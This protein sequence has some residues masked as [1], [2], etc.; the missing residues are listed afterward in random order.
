MT[1]SILPS[2]ALLLALPRPMSFP[3]T[4][5]FRHGGKGNPEWE[6]QEI[7]PSGFPAHHPEFWL[8]L[9]SEDTPNQFYFSFNFPWPLLWFWT[10]TDSSRT[11]QALEGWW[12]KR[13]DVQNPHKDV[14]RETSPQM[15]SEV[16][17]S[18][19]CHSAF[20]SLSQSLRPGRKTTTLSPSP[21]HSV[22][23]AQAPD[24]RV[25]AETGG[26]ER[27]GGGHQ[28]SAFPVSSPQRTGVVLLTGHSSRGQGHSLSPPFECLSPLTSVC[29]CDARGQKTKKEKKFFFKEES[30][31]QCWWDYKW[32]PLFPLLLGIS[33]LLS[34]TT[35][36]GFD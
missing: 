32:R 10:K 20:Q 1:A 22:T 4:Q 35:T 13:R 9:H 25:A 3:I 26:N 31:K 34:V 17:N 30:G 21:N 8:R 28:N 33:L 36:G 27:Q 6:A 2:P 24:G 23:K 16:W 7:N 19:T 12:G 14:N 11:S 18:H 15:P 29:L 5:S